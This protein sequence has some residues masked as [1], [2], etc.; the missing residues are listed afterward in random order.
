MASHS[1]GIKVDRSTEATEILRR[2]RRER[3]ECIT[4]G[5]PSK[6]RQRCNPCTRAIERNTDRYRGEQARRGAPSKISLDLKDLA[7]IMECAAKAHA[8]FGAVAQYPDLSR[9]QREQHLAEPLAQVDLL[10]RFAMDILD[11]NR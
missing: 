5:K 9:S 6:K 11:R 10:R 3:G 8:G 1:R 4:C 7:Y 2:Q